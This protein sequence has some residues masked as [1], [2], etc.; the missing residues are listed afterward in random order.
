MKNDSSAP[1]CDLTHI[2][3]LSCSGA[4]IQGDT[5]N[6]SVYIKQ[7]RSTAAVPIDDSYS[8]DFDE[9]SV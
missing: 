8:E 3:L 7:R 4:P 2:P 1:A 6:N 5:K 9:L